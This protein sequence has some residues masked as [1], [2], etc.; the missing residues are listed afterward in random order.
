MSKANEDP[1]QETG[2]T[3]LPERVLRFPRPMPPR[4][5]GW[6]DHAAH[7][8][9]VANHKASA[10]AQGVT[11]HTAK[12]LEPY[13]R[14]TIIDRDGQEWEV[15]ARR[16][17]PGVPA[18]V[19]KPLE[20][21]LTTVSGDS[22]IGITPGTFGAGAVDVS[23]D[24]DPLEPPSESQ[25]L[26][27]R[28]VVKAGSVG[29]QYLAEPGV[30]R[31]YAQ[32]ISELVEWSLDFL[33]PGVA[34]A[35]VRAEVSSTTG[36]STNNGTYFVRIGRVEISGSSVASVRNYK[37]GHIALNLCTGGDLVIASIEP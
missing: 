26:A 28:I 3:R 12:T 7:L 31:Y 32:G 9:E 6:R 30:I 35:S 10:Q 24:Q 21:Y 33:D 25:D 15:L 29:L 36:A 23:I 17:G 19:R 11:I 1:N 18:T 37:F 14:Q 34:N 5:T 8:A 4:W 20:L 22:R 27:L 13:T 2:A 16:V